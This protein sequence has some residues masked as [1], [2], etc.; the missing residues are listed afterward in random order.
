MSKNLLFIL[1]PYSG[2]AQI[3][4]K[5]LKIVDTF[6]AN[7]WNTS[8]HPTQSRNDAFETAKSLGASYDLV[9]V[10]GGDGTLS[11]TIRGIISIPEERRPNLGYIP[12][13]TTNDFASNLKIPK[14]ML[15]AAENIMSGRSFKCDV[16]LFNTKSFVY[17]SAFGA[18]TDVAY[19]TPQQTKNAL[20]QFA[21]FLEGIKKLYSLKSQFITVKYDGLT[22][23]DEFIFGMVSNT[24]YVGGFKTAKAF[25]SQLNDG[26]FEVVLIRR[27]KN[28]IEFQDLMARLVMMDLSSDLFY[29]FKANNIEFE[30]AE[31][32]SW[33][34]DGEYGGSLCNVN[35]K[36]IQEAFSM[37]L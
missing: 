28:I 20:G 31:P 1:N 12:S 17:V 23:S 21:Y 22:I 35:I 18:F 30:S 14:D 26:L 29:I 9:V 15:R 3:K 4:N 5:L 37:L 11:E 34:L 25:K 24:S 36:I 13:G 8:V 19:A 7:G 2:K 27:P 32:V 33:T 6:V 16:G 10:S